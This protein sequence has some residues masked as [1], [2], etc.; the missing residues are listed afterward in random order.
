MILHHRSMILGNYLTNVVVNGR[1][2]GF[3][4]LVLLAAGF[5][6]VS[7]C[8][9]EFSDLCFASLPSPDAEK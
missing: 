4:L 5:V 1:I 9:M 6:F 2:W 7:G 3:G 8:V